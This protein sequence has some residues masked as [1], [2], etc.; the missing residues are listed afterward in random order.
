MN[1]L[2]EDMID[3]MTTQLQEWDKSD[4]K[5]I[6][7]MKSSGPAFCAGG[8]VKSFADPT[9]IDV[10]MRQVQ[11]MY[12]LSHLIATLD[13]P[14][15]AVLDGV[16][17]GGGLGISVHAPFRIATENTI[18]GIPEGGIGFF[19]D[20]ALSF[21]LSRLPDGSRLGKYLALTGRMLKGMEAVMA[22]I[23]THYVPS[24][25]IPALVERLSS[26]STSDLREINH[27]IE[28]FA[29]STPSKAEW[30]E[31]SLHNELRLAFESLTLFSGP[32]QSPWSTATLA[33]MRNQSPTYMKVV[34][35]QLK[36][37]KSMDIA[38]CFRMDYR[39][40]HGFMHTPDLRTGITAVLVDKLKKRPEWNP[41]LEEVLGGGVLKDRDV[42]RIYFGD[43]DADER[44]GKEVP[45]EIPPEG[46]GLVLHNDRTFEQYVHRTVTGLP[47]EEDIRRVVG[48]EIAGSGNFA[49]TADEVVDWF[50]SNWGAF[51][52]P[53]TLG[54]TSNPPPASMGGGKYLDESGGDPSEPHTR[55]EQRRQPWG[56]RQRVEAIVDTCCERFGEGGAYLRWRRG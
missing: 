35:E 46:S 17:I 5:V 37:A 18:V 38:S 4:C 43:F 1:A 34:V 13:T 23:A 40:A 10:S 48:G 28:E 2:S 29:G 50:L 49:L 11:K 7:V 22:G 15:V 45:P 26:I 39:I 8:D 42:A 14:Y 52:D 9:N 51:L 53:T 20:T 41:S 24:D 25:R 33:H 21:F 3:T 30:E 16:A 12:S 47:A 54:Y 19:A 56:V 55:R 32:Q 44:E 27:V 36:R 6:F 31:W